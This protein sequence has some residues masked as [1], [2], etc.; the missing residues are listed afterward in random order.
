MVYIANWPQVEDTK[1]YFIS[2]P[3]PVI[4][5]KNGESEAQGHTTS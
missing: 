3:S 2:L 4:N 5:D 1:N